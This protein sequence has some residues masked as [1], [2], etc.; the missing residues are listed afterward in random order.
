MLL[1]ILHT[2][3]VKKKKINETLHK[4]ML[5]IYIACSITHLCQYTHC[6]LGWR[7]LFKGRRR[8][9][10]SW[11]EGTAPQSEVG[12]GWNDAKKHKIQTV[13]TRDGQCAALN[14]REKA[15]EKQHFPGS[16]AGAASEGLQPVSPRNEFNTLLIIDAHQN[17]D[18]THTWWEC[19]HFSPG[20]CI[21]WQRAVNLLITLDKWNIT[22]FF[23]VIPAM[24]LNW[25]T[26]QVEGTNKSRNGLGD[27][28]ARL[29]PL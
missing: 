18:V 7:I 11:T 26:V 3:I 21:L 24:K 16:T 23:L 22:F 5:W 17:T 6:L 13:W 2:H 8:Q 28:K 4:C 12:E 20:W 9:F 27:K 29:K 14:Q 1:Y 19:I 15:A 25:I 10:T